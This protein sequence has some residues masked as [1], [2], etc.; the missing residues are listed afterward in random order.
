VLKA[1]SKATVV[2]RMTKTS[3]ATWVSIENLVEFTFHQ[4]KISKLA[5]F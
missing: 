4:F 2:M 5:L 1:N 3:R